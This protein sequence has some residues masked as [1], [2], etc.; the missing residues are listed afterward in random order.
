MHE[1]P[2]DAYVQAINDSRI[3]RKTLVV[4]LDCARKRNEADGI[5]LF[6][7]MIRCQEAR[8]RAFVCEMRNEIGATE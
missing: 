2:P 3:C 5:W 7:E 1:F 8:E 4:L 6:E